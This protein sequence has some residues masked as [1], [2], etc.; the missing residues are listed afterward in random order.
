MFGSSKY[1]VERIYK[2][3]RDG[4]VEPFIFH[5]ENVKSFDLYEAEDQY[6]QAALL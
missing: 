3:D 4:E 1:L 6:E 5:L 2:F